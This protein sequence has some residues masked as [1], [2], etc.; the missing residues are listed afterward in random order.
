MTM[1]EE[2][3]RMREALNAIMRYTERPHPTYREARI[4]L[5]A[6]SALTGDGDLEALIAAVIRSVELDSMPAHYPGE[7]G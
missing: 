4:G 3:A 1:D 5:L 2:I 7:Q 6:N